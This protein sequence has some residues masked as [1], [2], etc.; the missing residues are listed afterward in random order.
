MAAGEHPFIDIAVRDEVRERFAAGDAL[1][2][3]DAA[4]DTVL[5]ANGP[6]AA[7]FAGTDVGGLIG[8]PAPLGIA[9]KRQISGLYGFPRAGRERPVTIRVGASALNVLVSGVDLDGEPAVLL[10]VMTARRPGAAPALHKA[11]EGLDEPGQYL[12]LLGDDGRI[13]AASEGFG[14]LAIAP[15]T[16]AQ[17]VRQVA[18]EADRLV[19]RLIPTSDGRTVA[20]GIGRLTDAPAFH[21]LVVVDEVGPQTET[22]VPEEQVDAAAASE[23]PDPGETARPAEQQPTVSRTGSTFVRLPADDLDVGAEFIPAGADEGAV[24]NASAAPDDD[25]PTRAEGP[26]RF[27]WRTDGDGRFSELS[28]DLAS[29]VGPP[30]ADVVGR[31]MAEVCRDF[32]M[33]PAG[34]IVGLME[35]RDTWSG[36][37]LLWPI[38]G[39]DLRVPVDLAALPVY[40]R[41]RN[42]EGFRGFGVARA[43][44]AVVDPDARGLDFA[45]SLN[46]ASA[47]DAEPAAPETPSTDSDGRPDDAAS[48]RRPGPG[49][50][51]GTDAATRDQPAL[52]LVPKPD[53]PPP[54]PQRVVQLSEHRSAANDRGGLSAIEQTAFREIGDRLRREGVIAEHEAARVSREGRDTKTDPNVDDAPAMPGD[55][56]P[57]TEVDPDAPI[58]EAGPAEGFGGDPDHVHG[59]SEPNSSGD[60]DVDPAAGTIVAPGRGDQESSG[61][62]FEDEPDRLGSDATPHAPPAMA[63]SEY[64]DDFRDA[65]EEPTGEIAAAEATAG[66]HGRAGDEPMAEAVGDDDEAGFLPS[67]FANEGR[68]SRPPIDTSILDKL[69][70]PVLIHAGDTLHYA[71]REFLDFTA[72]GDIEDLRRAG[73]LGALF[74]EPYP[75]EEFGGDRKLR[76]RRADGLDVPVEAFLQSAPWNGGIALLLSLRRIG[77]A[78]LPTPPMLVQAN[79]P[80]AGEKASLEMRLA[81]LRTIIDTA[82]DGVV[83]LAEDATIRSISRPAE[84][85]FG[86]DSEDVAGKPF[87]SLFAVESQRAARDYLN[88]LAE[89]GVASVLNDG[90]EVIGR[91]AEGRFIPLFM[92]I[93]RLPN[94]SGY[95]AVLRDITQ[96]KRA[97]EDLTQAR[98][99]AERASS[100]KTEFLAR[101]SHEIRTPL[102]AIIGF[103][104]LMMDEKFGPVGNDRYRDYLRDINKSGN[105]VLDLV[106]DLLDI[107][108]IEAGQQEM[109]YEAV[110]LNDMLAESVAMMQPQANRE[111]VIIRSSF[112]SSLPDVVADTRTIRQIALNLLS[113]AIR[114]TQAGGQV[115]VSTAYETSGDVVLRFRDTGIGMSPS[116]I[117]QALK[118]FKQINAI[119]RPRGDGTG[120]GLPLTKAMVEA[121]RARFQILSTPGEGTLVEITFPSTRVLAD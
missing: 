55:E 98:A 14:G 75:A 78:P 103:S 108:K 38:A 33:D 99:Q 17:L 81:E 42:F 80:S 47:R 26:V 36:R 44:D 18:G 20:A 6:G 100:Q 3:L 7:L 96:W 119:K 111:R 113:N 13:E 71:N 46:D 101:V 9:P 23:Q 120:L 84:A 62:Q 15:D 116:E 76:L 24:P 67:A 109:S 63:H 56:Q 16:L 43:G 110:P 57:A 112:A 48:R 30:A 34:E 87:V 70:V 115:I 92:T 39:T 94:R 102:N 45:A 117:E 104:E 1:L 65:G 91:E 28:G 74:E 105:H 2:M 66:P 114:Y 85:L 51:H 52:R 69:P 4:L 121:N 11:I 77:R 79:Q 8:S 50:Q 49:A 73:G 93:G 10:A 86:L 82:T 40:D 97:E 21:L 72:Y 89:N 106:N 41:A 31:T 118:P 53:T 35:R 88:G 25:K 27:V 5:W 12:A 19:K 83:L 58:L 68:R 90:R 29:I 54:P 61:L 95:C 60:T 107:S 22:A 37:S 59:P 64:V 32:G